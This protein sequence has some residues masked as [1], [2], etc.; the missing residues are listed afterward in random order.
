MP[1]FPG[2]LEGKCN[3]PCRKTCSATHSHRH[4][5]YKEL[6]MALIEMNTNVFCFSNE[7]LKFS[8][9]QSTK[10]MTTQS[11]CEYLFPGCL[12]LVYWSRWKVH[13][14]CRFCKSYAQKNTRV[15]K[16]Q[17]RGRDH[18]PCLEG[19]DDQ[20]WCWA[21]SMIYICPIL[22]WQRKGAWM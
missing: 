14:V 18:F 20:R 2:Y 8:P 6:L 19:V 16:N 12:V 15:R 17:W 21:R 4:A 1:L 9:H 5:V 7:A 3:S 13:C 22:Q 11:I 10:G